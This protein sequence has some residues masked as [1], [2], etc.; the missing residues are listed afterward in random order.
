[1][2]RL[3][4]VPLGP[5]RSAARSGRDRLSDEAERLIDSL[6][7]GPLPEAVA[8]S[9]VEHQVLRR[10]VEEALDEGA[11]SD[12]DDM[13]WVVERV[14]KSPALERWAAS[15]E[16]ARLVGPIVGRVAKSPELRDTV[17][18]LVGSPE[19]RRALEAQTTG[20]GGELAAAARV[21]AA[22]GDDHFEARVRG[23][24]RRG[25]RP[26][27]L[28]YGGFV[29]RGIA[30][31]FDIVLAHLLAL[32][33]A[34]SVVLALT[35]VGLSH[36]G[37]VERATTGGVWVCVAAAYFIAFWSWLGQTPGMRLLRLRVTT[38][39]G[40][41][42]S[43]P[44]AILRYLGLLL[45]I[46]PLGAG[47]L[48]ALVDNRR[49]ALQDVIAGTVV[50][51]AVG[52]GEP[53]TPV[54]AREPSAADLVPPPRLAVP[55][56][57]RD[58][59]PSG[60]RSTWVRAGGMRIHTV[61]GGAGP[62]VV[63]VH[64]FAVS[65]AYMLPLARLLDQSASVYI[66]D[67]PGHGR[68][69]PPRGRWAIPEMAQL[70]GDWIDAAGVDAPVL[71]AN[72][73]GCQVV[74]ELAVQRPAS[75]G[76]LVLV[77]PTMDPS[78]RAAR[79]QL[80]DLMRDSRREPFAVLSQAARDNVAPDLKWLLGSARAAL[81]DRIEERLPA[82]EQPVVVVHGGD[83]GF[84]SLEW[85]QTVA[86]LLPNGRLVLVQDAPHAVHY[87]RPDLVADIVCEL[88]DAAAPAGAAAA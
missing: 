45:A 38:A 31:V 68:T 5:L 7:A 40:R 56:A 43:L 88:L 64:G 17:V 55:P 83:D 60:L 12:G 72:S 53:P 23:L 75:V 41:D 20:F 85:A 39:D 73:L 46:V 86:R 2:V 28:P 66:P 30:L 51:S 61:A 69:E 67:L 54:E 3:D 18:A 71:V 57:P 80:L 11:V 87:T 48:L 32:A 26:T 16:A 62:P 82:I 84:V 79:H 29:S 77:G 50:I 10:V 22:H 47:L 37:I 8:R 36:T 6:L 49:R 44:R 63:L 9:V 21:R 13:E 74:T 58:R 78:R 19:F 70:L 52:A 24:V 76:A 1:V 42:V 14:L 4:Q 34:A 81:S 33:A 35:L 59:V 65:G 25:P 27:I 15:D